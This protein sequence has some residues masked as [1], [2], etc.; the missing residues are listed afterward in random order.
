MTNSHVEHAIHVA[1][2]A[3]KGQ[4][5]K[6]G[7][8]YILHALR[9]GLQGITA[10]EQ[11]VG[12]LHDVLEDTSYPETALRVMFGAEVFLAVSTLTHTPGESYRA[13]IYRVSKNPLARAVKMHDIKDNLSRAHK[14][15]QDV[16]LR[17]ERKYYMALAILTE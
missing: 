14:L 12:F 7:Q 17:L 8:P 1:I 15:P 10:V 16:R 9:V 3:H 11:I 5:D 2:I 6:Q 4:L 13:Y